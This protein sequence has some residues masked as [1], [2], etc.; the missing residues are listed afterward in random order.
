MHELE[1]KLCHS[2]FHD[3]NNSCKHQ[4]NHSQGSGSHCHYLDLLGIVLHFLYN[5]FLHHRLV[6]LDVDHVV[7]VHLLYL[8]PVAEL[9][10]AAILTTV[11]LLLELLEMLRLYWVDGA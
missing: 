3:K 1:R 8:T 7:V 5:D 4:D 11:Q 10:K 2:I 6:A 9:V